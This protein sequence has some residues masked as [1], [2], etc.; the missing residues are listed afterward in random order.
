MARGA[1][2]VPSGTVEPARAV[3]LRAECLRLCSKC[4]GELLC[5]QLERLGPEASVAHERAAGFVMGWASHRARTSTERL[6]ERWKSFRK[7]PPFWS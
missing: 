6:G 1:V 5:E 3:L 2:P 7:T 4:L